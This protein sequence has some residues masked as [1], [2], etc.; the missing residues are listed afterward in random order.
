MFSIDF[1]SLITSQCR[2]FNKDRLTRAHI[3]LLTINYHEHTLILMNHFPYLYGNLLKIEKQFEIQT[4]KKNSYIQRFFCTI[5]IDILVQRKLNDLNSYTIDR[6][7]IES[8]NKVNLTPVILHSIQSSINIS[9][10]KL[11]WKPF[12]F[13]NSNIY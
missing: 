1:P 4:T 6:V 10:I 3:V 7:T 13:I 9:V 11:I 2:V 8:S 12:I 5:Y